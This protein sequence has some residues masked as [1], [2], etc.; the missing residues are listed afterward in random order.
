MAAERGSPSGLEADWVRRAAWGGRA[1]ST[2]HLPH[3]PQLV[4]H[5]FPGLSWLEAPVVPLS[6][7]SCVTH[8]PQPTASPSRS[9]TSLLDPSPA[10]AP[11]HPPLPPDGPW[12]RETSL[13][14]GLGLGRAPAPAGPTARS[15]AAASFAIYGEDEADEAGSAEAAD[16][17][18]ARGQAGAAA[19]GAEAEAEVT[20]PLRAPGPR[21][22]VGAGG[23][24]AGLPRRSPRLLRVPLSPLAARPT[25]RRR[26]LASPR[27]R[28]APW[29]A[30]GGEGGGDGGGLL[31]EAGDEGG[32]L[33][34][35]VA[36]GVA[37]AAAD[38]DEA[39]LLRCLDQRDE[40]RRRSALHSRLLVQLSPGAAAVGA[41]VGELGL[42]WGGEA[43]ADAEE[44][45][46]EWAGLRLQHHDHQQQQQQ[47]QEQEGD[48]E[49][50]PEGD[51]EGVGAEQQEGVPVPGA[52]EQRG[53]PLVSGAAPAGP[54]GAEA[55]EAEAEVAAC[56]GRGSPSGF[57]SVAHMRSFGAEAVRAL[58][59]VEGAA[60]PPPAGPPPHLSVRAAL[61]SQAPPPRT[62]AQRGPR[63]P[64]RRV[65]APAGGPLPG[66]RG[67]PRP[68]DSFFCGAKDPRGPPAAGSDCTARAAPAPASAPGPDGAFF[69]SFDLTSDGEE[70]RSGGE[71]SD[72]ERLER[73]RTAPPGPA[74]QRHAAAAQALR[75]PFQVPRAAG[76]APAAG[77]GRGGKDAGAAA[78]LGAAARDGGG[79]RGVAVLRGGGAGSGV[80]GVS[81]PGAAAP[82]Q[83]ALDLRRFECGPSLGP[84]KRLMG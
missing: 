53:R 78:R 20:S 61:P 55:D 14:L 83:A 6:T 8:A 59:A 10:S 37:A 69:A 71:G 46:L 49:G 41:D 7:P 62:A 66:A 21:S 2:A 4:G 31:G 26:L 54:G 47:E 48:Q 24:G 1:H 3:Q 11:H 80:R 23:G 67:G 84:R 19:A 74:A 16:W 9:R 36:R 30:G 76:A 56:G 25:A 15:A 60:R 51:T 52:A 65:S 17:P 38:A 33:G 43:A 58:D 75:R 44:A 18:W 64:P 12:R 22:G 70:G 68:I 39:A 42:A 32:G 63:E 82:L 77:G 81:V 40:R 45:L 29:S 13:G 27:Q 79:A 28:G 5:R 72:V 50:E 73:P 34:E 35:E 57:L